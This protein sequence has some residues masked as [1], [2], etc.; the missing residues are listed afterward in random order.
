V[1]HIFPQ[2]RLWLSFLLEKTIKS[3]F[4][5]YTSS[6][7]WA[8]RRRPIKRDLAGVLHEYKPGWTH[9][10]EILNSTDDLG[11]W[12][13]LPMLDNTAGYTQINGELTYANSFNSSNYYRSVLRSAI[14]RHFGTI[15][16]VTE[17]G[18]GIGRNLLYLKQEFPALRC[19][20]YELVPEGVEIAQHAARK[21]GADIQYA[22]L[23]Y[24]RD[25]ND[26]FK[27]PSTDLAFTMFSLEQLPSQC[28][29]ALKNILLRSNRG[30][31]HLEPV[32]ENY[33]Y[34]LRGMIARVQHRKM[35]YLSGFP[36]AVAEQKLKEVIY[37]PMTSSH[38]P[39]MFP[40]MYALK[41]SQAAPVA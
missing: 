34:S 22:Q 11:T 31:V 26:K 21:F 33:P 20:G 37:E 35:G 19:F 40:S 25:G 9:F 10:A 13:N 36:K 32:P 7:Y 4:E 23:D 41:K 38:N 12:L 15:D 30:S 8:L 5:F 3:K 2:N 27:F 18:C 29:V 39:L 24:L 6:L 1:Q 14:E 17:Y 28:N 16:S